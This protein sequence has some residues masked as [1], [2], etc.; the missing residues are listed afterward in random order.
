MTVT[1]SFK[2]TVKARIGR[3][4]EFR[5][6]L[7]REGIDCLLSGDVDTGKAVLRDYINATIGFENLGAVTNTPPKSLMRMFSQKGNP[8][9]KNLFAVIAH[10]QTQSGIHLEVRAV[11]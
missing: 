2:D 9:A 10:L 8:Q 4:A 1:R 6:T 7:L 3:D 11:K 5:E